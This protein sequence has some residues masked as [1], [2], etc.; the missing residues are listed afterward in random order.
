MNPQAES[1]VSIA[2]IAKYLLS[3]LLLI[4]GITAF[5]Y[6]SDVQLLYRVLGLVLMFGASVG[7][8]F[9]T[10]IGKQLWGFFLESKQEV[11]RV[12]WPTKDETVRTTL[13]VSA[14]VFIVGLLLWV[15]DLTLSWAIQLVMTQGAA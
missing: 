5:Y 12:V 3:T 13:M 6:F 14:M 9:L 1:V 11:K 10:Q 4:V 8:F 7:T 15:V 2:D